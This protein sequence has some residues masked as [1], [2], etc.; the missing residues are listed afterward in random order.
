M[1]RI[2]TMKQEDLVVRNIP[3]VISTNEDGVWMTD[4]LTFLKPDVTTKEIRYVINYLYE[5]GLIADR[6]IQYEVK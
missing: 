3:I 6:R 5:E 4:L 1:V 2:Q